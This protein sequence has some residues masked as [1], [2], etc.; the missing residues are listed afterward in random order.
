M[1]N[2]TYISDNAGHR[3]AVPGTANPIV[4]TGQTLADAVIGGDD[5]VTVVAGA[6][7]AI[8]CTAVGAMILGIA[9]VTTAANIIWV[10][11]ANGEAIIVIPSGATALHFAGTVNTTT[12]YL[13]RIR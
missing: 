6:V 1:T 4:A 2:D 5:T 11:P 3:V 7:Y 12:A 13:R 8:T 10:V 9:A